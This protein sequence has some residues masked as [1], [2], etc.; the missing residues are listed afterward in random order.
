MDGLSGPHNW[1][2]EARMPKNQ[3]RSWGISK[4]IEKLDWL[5]G[6]GGRLH[7]GE[8]KVKAALAVMESSSNANCSI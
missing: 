7:R 2:E 5:G 4:A 6:S 3:T 8:E 1:L